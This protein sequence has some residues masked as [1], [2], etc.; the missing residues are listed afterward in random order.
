[1]TKKNWIAVIVLVSLLGVTS[2]CKSGGE[3]KPAE[4]APE[5]AASAPA[6]QKASPAESRNP[7]PTP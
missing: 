7:T 3:A 4:A 6:E 5:A 1:M 2:A